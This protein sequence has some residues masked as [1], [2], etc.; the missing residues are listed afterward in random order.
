MNPQFFPSLS[1]TS[2]ED[3]LPLLLS[4]SLG[5]QTVPSTQGT[6]IGGKGAGHKL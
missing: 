3:A 5:S 1:A 2:K 6:E 4:E